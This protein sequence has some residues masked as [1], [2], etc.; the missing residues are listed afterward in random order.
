MQRAADV[1]W[2]AA[3]V[4]AHVPATP[5][6]TQCL[7][8]ISPWLAPPSPPADDPTA[9]HSTLALNLM[10]VSAGLRACTPD[11]LTRA[12]AFI[13][14][15]EVHTTAVPT[16]CNRMHSVRHMRAAHDADQAADA[17]HG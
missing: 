2:R 17:L 11:A 15:Q 9:W 14:L 8:C 12:L 6:H 1:Q 10:A 13:S 7:T 4:C 3:L 5:A 16:R